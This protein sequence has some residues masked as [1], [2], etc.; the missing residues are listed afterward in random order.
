MR[1]ILVVLA[2]VVALGAGVFVLGN[3]ACQQPPIKTSEAN[4]S[5]QTNKNNCASPY[6]IFKVGLSEIWTFAKGSDKEIVA[7]STVLAAFFTIILG[8]ATVV[9]A[10]FTRELVRSTKE[11]AQHQLRAYVHNRKIEW[12][13]GRRIHAPW[14]GDIGWAFTFEWHN[15]GPTRARK[16]LNH[17]SWD[18][19]VTFEGDMPPEFAFEDKGRPMAGPVYIPPEDSTWSE[20]LYI[21][22]AILEAVRVGQLRLFVWGWC[23]YRD[24]FPQ[25]DGRDTQ[26]CFELNRIDGNP[27]EHPPDAA[28]KPTIFFN[29]R[30]A[31]RH[32][33]ADEDCNQEQQIEIRNELPLGPPP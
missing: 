30:S 12:K 15:S 31:G 4:A 20:S 33:C 19:Y 10:S 1:G 18:T 26:F 24:I 6:A 9:L 5:A 29:F 14:G 2:L 25:S 32:N 16:F 22:A 3:A 13:A 21:E 11:T 8:V 17:V 23:T 27:Y 28:T 7:F